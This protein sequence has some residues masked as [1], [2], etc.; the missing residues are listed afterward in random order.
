MNN[1]TQRCTETNR[2]FALASEEM[3][4]I[5]W[6]DPAMSSQLRYYCPMCESIEL[7]TLPDV[8]TKIIRAMR[9]QKEALTPPIIDTLKDSYVLTEEDEEKLHQDLANLPTAESGDNQ[10]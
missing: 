6:G 1:V 5:E 3:S 10:S 9:T 7:K 4:L 8:Q 2:Q